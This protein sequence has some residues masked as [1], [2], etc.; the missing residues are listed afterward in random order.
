[1]IKRNNKGFTLIE[2]LVVIAIIGALSAAVMV[3]LTGPQRSARDGKRK[4]DLEMIRQGLELYRADCG[5]YPA[6]LPA[7]GSNLTGTNGSSTSPCYNQNIY[8]RNRPADPRGYTYVYS[9]GAGNRTYTLCGSLERNTGTL[10]C[11]GAASNACGGTGCN[12]VLNS[13]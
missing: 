3:M 9:A 13:P 10:A 4:S 1:M 5:N 8:I 6:A 7:V 2:L 12:Y 11:G